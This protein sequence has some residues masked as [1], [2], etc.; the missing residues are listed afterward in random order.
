MCR[1]TKTGEAPRH[2]RWRGALV[3]YYTA[4]ARLVGS[5]P[6]AATQLSRS[7]QHTLHRLSTALLH[8]PQQRQVCR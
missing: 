7:W 5:T 1:D 6:L 3:D 8:E 2:W 4:E